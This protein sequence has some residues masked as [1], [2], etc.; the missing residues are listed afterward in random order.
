MTDDRHDASLEYRAV[1]QSV[2]L[3][4]RGD[5]GI[6]EVTGR[7]RATFLHAML[8]NDV[9]SLSPGQGSAAA[10]LDVHGKVQTFLWLWALEDRLLMLTPPGLAG[11]T[12]EALERYLFS[13]KAYLRA[14]TGEGG[15]LVLAGP[16]AG[17]MLARL[18]GGQVPERAWDHAPATLADVQA[19]VVRGSGESGE[20]EVWIL[21][22]AAESARVR[23][24]ALAAGATRVRPEVWDVL[25]IEAGTPVFGAD[26]DPSVLLPE[27]PLLDRVSYTKGCYLGQEVVVRIRDR[28][29]VNRMLSGL[30]LD[31]EPVPAKGAR[32][33]VGG[34]E[35]GRVTSAAWSW[36]LKRPIALGFL[37]RQHAEPGTRVDVAID[38]GLA[39]ATV[40]T[41]PF[42]R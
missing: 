2:G 15:L 1:R 26:V 3:I 39:T 12:I 14:A 8:T 27:V 7:D 22:A 34:A 38:G 28:G 18:G 41:L 35:I 32:V 24:A 9:K 6:V 19:R 13:E 40:S 17:E 5:F 42:A 30:V 37:K 4:D 10:L 25:R 16:G 21:C 31:A 11:P 20:T 29:H 23:D 33:S 36:A